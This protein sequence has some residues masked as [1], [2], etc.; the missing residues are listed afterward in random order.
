MIEKTIYLSHLYDSY[1]SN[2]I[3][4]HFNNI[5][6]S[7]TSD[8]IRNNSEVAYNITTDFKRHYLDTESEDEGEIEGDIQYYN[9]DIDIN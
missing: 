5:F 9:Y 4:D 2:Q 6:D 3:E 7:N 1:K 8:L